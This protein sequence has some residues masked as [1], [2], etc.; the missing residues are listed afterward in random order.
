ML[1]LFHGT[2]VEK[3]RTK[4]FEWVAKA[5]A[6]EPNL[7]YVRLAREELS[8]T[9]LHD[10][11]LSGGLFVKRLLI[12]VDDP[13]PAA[14]AVNDEEGEGEETAAESVLEDHLDALATSDNAIIILAPKLSAAKAKK[15]A[16]KAKMEYAFD[17]LATFEVKRGFNRNLVEALGARNRAKLWLEVNRALVAGDA[18][19]MLHGLLHWKARDLMEKGSRSWTPRESRELSLALIELLQS[20]RRGGLALSLALERFALSV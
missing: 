4:A 8:D 11:A 2:D 14:R 17:K 6:K 15:L 3:A 19:E 20:S 9:V 13:F 5:R 7:A 12:L 1:Y 18:P 10:A 16:A